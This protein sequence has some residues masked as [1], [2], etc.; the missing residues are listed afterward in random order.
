MGVSTVLTTC[1]ERAA[2]AGLFKGQLHC[3][4]PWRATMGRFGWGGGRRYRGAQ[5]RDDPRRLPKW[6]R[7]C[8]GPAIAEQRS[9][10]EQQTAAMGSAVA[11][12]NSKASARR[13]AQKCVPEDGELA[14]E[15]GW[16][17]NRPLRGLAVPRSGAVQAV[18]PV[19]NAGFQ[20]FLRP[21]LTLKL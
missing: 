18:N 8:S 11:G 2:A 10:A 21:G 3:G 1:T 6:R 19:R 20:G 13:E 16:A 12:K 4:L 9:A 14:G 15:G 17:D 7:E 5:R